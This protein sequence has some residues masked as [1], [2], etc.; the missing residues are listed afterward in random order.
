MAS[1]GSGY[2]LSASTFSPDGRIFQVEYATK[3]VENAGPVL[4]IRCSGG[5]VL[6]VAKPIHHKMV[7]ATSGSYKRI[8][9]CDTHVGCASTGFLPDARVLVQRTVEEAADWED[10]YGSKIP[11]S[12]LADRLGAYVHYFTLYEG[13]RPF[14]A[15][16]VLAGYDPDTGECSLHLMEPNGAPSR[17]Y[18]VA[19]GKGKQAAKTELEKLNLHKGGGGGGG[20]G[21]AGGITVDEAVRQIL[22]ILHLL[23]H[24]QK[25]AKPIE[26]EVSWICEASGWKHQPVPPDVV[27]AAEE[28]AKAQLEEE[29]DDD[30]EEEGM[31]E[32]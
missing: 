26:V 32:G 16:A 4:G 7:V 1:S 28:W 10:Q 6:G 14:G 17:Y 31:E 19:T 11:P 25:D 8:H 13:L 18:G 20:A 30:E 27:K 24:E 12:V 29:D 23:H 21:D 5:V 22:R 2:D 15:A 9:T 3:A